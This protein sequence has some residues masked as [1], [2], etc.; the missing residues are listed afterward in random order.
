MSVLKKNSFPSF[1]ETE[2]DILKTYTSFRDKYHRQVMNELSGSFKHHAT[3]NALLERRPP[4]A[5]EP[6]MLA[7]EHDAIYNGKWEEFADNLV[8]QGVYYAQTKVENADWYQI[9]KR[10]SDFLTAHIRRD[11]ISSADEAVMLL[12][13]L[14]R[15]VE[16]AVH[17]VTMGYSQQRNTELE[18]SEQRYRS[19]FENSAD[20]ILLID[21]VGKIMHINRVDT[22]RREDVIGTSLLSFQS[23]K[24]LQD[25]VGAIKYVFENGS[26]T[27]WASEYLVN[28]KP[29]FY[30]SSVSPIFTRDGNVEL[31]LVISRD[32]SDRKFAE[33]EVK[34]LNRELERKVLLRTE[35]LNSSMKD[36]EAFSYSVS[37]NLRTPLRAI[38]GFTQIL[39]E[40]F[41]DKLGGETL[42]AMNS[43]IRNARR[44][45]QLIDDLLEFSRIGK[46]Q[47]KKNIVDMNELVAGVIRELASPGGPKV[48]FQV[49]KLHSVKADRAMMRQAMMNLVSNAIK[50]SARKSEP[51]II[52]GSFKKD[53]DLV[54][55]VK[56][57][58]AGFDMK[59]YGKL[60]AVFQRLHR[61]DEFEGTGVGLA[62]VHRILSKHSGKIW[63]ESSVG[64][65]AAF[66]MS[67]PDGK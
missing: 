28:E 19:I 25:V 15:S 61:T 5:L 38:N 18:E 22:G 50:Y 62:I 64:E 40:D 29:C 6:R 24:N 1:D 67:L 33:D 44:M 60:F 34:R 42:E 58:G 7:L 26:H 59:Y 53:E 52:I 23:D 8:L 55:F 47:V 39:I 17:L 36:I 21:R 10:Y 43:I 57:N 16:Y 45:S 48:S 31:A 27:S 66:Y 2:V 13:G 30:E 49:D 20:Q 35:E 54:F 11:L 56:D 51:L 65:G 14:S 3:L 37:H 9:L 46:R 41:G 63:A 12:T 32:I 4:G